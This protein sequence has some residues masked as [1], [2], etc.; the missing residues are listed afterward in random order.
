MAVIA[1][2]ALY[3]TLLSFRAAMRLQQTAADEMLQAFRERG[4]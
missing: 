3:L 2:T 4:E 1:F